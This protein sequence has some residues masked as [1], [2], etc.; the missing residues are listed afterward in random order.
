MVK[1]LKELRSEE[2]LNGWINMSNSGIMVNSTHYKNGKRHNED[3]PA[4]ILSD[5]QYQYL[6]EHYLGDVHYPDPKS[7]LEWLLTVKKWKKAGEVT[8]GWLD[9]GLYQIHYDK[10][11]K[12][13]E[14]GP[15][16]IKDGVR[17]YFLANTEYVGYNDKTWKKYCKKRYK[18]LSG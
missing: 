13:N 6:S 5:G 1:N 4:W 15:A 2:P 12:H 11:M 17:K 14:A 18:R 3:G 10:D 9:Y 8:D 7:D 16:E